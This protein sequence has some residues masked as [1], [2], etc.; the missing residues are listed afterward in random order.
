MPVAV[1][2]QKMSPDEG[3]V[4]RVA[5]ADEFKSCIAVSLVLVLFPVEKEGAD[6]DRVIAPR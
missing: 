5:G 2:Q 1:D 4:V 6:A 3:G